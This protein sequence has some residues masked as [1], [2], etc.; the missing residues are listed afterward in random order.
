M[1]PRS[2]SNPAEYRLRALDAMQLFG[3][4]PPTALLVEL[5]QADDTLVRCKAAELMGLHASDAT[6]TRLLALLKDADPGVRRKACEALLHGPAGFPGPAQ[7]V[8]HF[9]GPARGL[10]ARRLLEQMPPEGWRTSVLT[11]DTQRLFIQGS[12]ALLTAHGDRENAQAVLKRFG[13]RLPHFISDRDFTDMLRWRELALIKGGLTHEQ[14]PAC[15]N[16]WPTSFPPGSPTSTASWCGC[17]PTCRSA[18][19]ARY[20]A[21]LSSEASDEE[22]L[23]LAMHLRYLRSGW[24]EG[25]RLQILEFLDQARRRQGAGHYAEYIAV[26]ERDLA[27]S[28]SDSEG[29]QVLARAAEWPYAAVGRSI[30][31]R[32]NCRTRRSRPCW[33][34]TGSWPKRMTPAATS[35]ASASW[36]SWH[37]AGRQKP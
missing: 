4:P 34:W 13:E 28:L 16:S 18:P 27:K 26:V 33:N 11:T 25:D 6:R 21:L 2:Q 32:P 19:R 29:E 35:C 10:G 22:K 20:L 24:E 30:T 3:P 15:V 23:H 37:A 12:L 8:P 7:P 36:R 5:S 1:S 14:L 17:W 31:C 9:P